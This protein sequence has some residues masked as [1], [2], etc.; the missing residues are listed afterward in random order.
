MSNTGSSH[1]TPTPQQGREEG[2]LVFSGQRMIS[3]S[4]QQLNISTICSL[5][6]AEMIPFELYSRRSRHTDTGRQA[7]ECAQSPCFP[8][9]QEGKSHEVAFPPHTKPNLRGAQTQPVHGRTLL[10]SPSATARVVCQ[11][12]LQVLTKEQG[13]D[14][15]TKRWQR[16]HLG[17]TEVCSRGR[18]TGGFLVFSSAG[19]PEKTCAS[20]VCPRVCITHTVSATTNLPATF[21]H[22][23][24]RSA[25]THITKLLTTFMKA[26]GQLDEG[27]CYSSHFRGSSPCEMSPW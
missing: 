1:T 27:P 23:H 6:V 26:S 2:L 24:Q 11:P 16:F 18:G 5:N 19:F 10:Q 13:A 8:K 20:P 21:T 17:F 14:E 9:K 12:L 3:V 25:D 7:H 4:L 15:D 22:I